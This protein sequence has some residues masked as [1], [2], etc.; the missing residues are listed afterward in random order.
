MGK[1]LKITLVALG[2]IVLI[3]AGFFGWGIKEYN[4]HA[5]V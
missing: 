2:I 5:E 4:N 1:G 3:G